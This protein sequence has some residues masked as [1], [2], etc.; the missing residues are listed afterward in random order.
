MLGSPINP[1][2]FGLQVGVIS[3]PFSLYLEMGYENIVS[4]TSVHIMGKFVI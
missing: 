2:L 3:G 1:D 4:E